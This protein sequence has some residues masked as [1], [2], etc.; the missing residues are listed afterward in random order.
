M[1]EFFAMGGYASYI[2]PAYGIAGGVILGLFIWSW[3]GL[4]KA[5]RDEAALGKRERRRAPRVE[6]VS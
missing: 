1:E 3:R 2:W 5:A 4:A 6:R